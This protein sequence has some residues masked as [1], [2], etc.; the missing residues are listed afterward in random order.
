MLIKIM[1]V[2]CKRLRQADRHVESLAFLSAPGRVARTLIE[3]SEDHGNEEGDK[4]IIS[5]K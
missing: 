5:I 4:V 2:L 1:A 3:L